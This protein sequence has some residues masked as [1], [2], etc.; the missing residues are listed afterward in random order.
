MSEATQ[1]HAYARL[2][3][4]GQFEC[5]M[6][7]KGVHCAACVQKIET[8]LRQHQEIV[9]ARLNFST[10]RL[11]VVWQGDAA[12]VD[13]WF[14]LVQ[15]LGYE[16]LPFDAR[17]LSDQNDDE[18]K[19]LLLCLGIAGFAM[20]NIMLLSIILWS[21]DATTLGMPARD[22]FHWVSALIALPAV[23]LGGRPFF[24][25]ALGALRQGRTNMDVPI[26]LAFILSCGTSLF[27]LFH[28]GEHV[29]FDSAVML[30]FFLLIGRFLDFRARASARSSARD[31]LS[32]MVGSAHVLDHDKISVMPIQDLQ[33]GMIVLVAMGER[34]P[35]DGVVIEGTSEID[36]SLLTGETM[37]QAIAA[38]QDIYSGALNIAAPLKIRIQRAAE[39]SLIADIV[40]LMEKAEQ[41][42]ARYVRIADR[43]ARLYTP[44]VHMLA[45]ATFIGWTFF[46]HLAWQQSL[47][48]ATAVLIITCPCALALA[49]PVVQVLAVGRLMKHGILVKSGDA[50]ERLA[51]I[52][53]VFLDKTGTLTLGRPSWMNAAAVMPEHIQIAASMAVHSRHPLSR[54]I[55]ESYQGDFLPMRV[56]EIPGKGLACDYHGQAIRLGNRYWCGDRAVSESPD[57]L[58]LWLNLAG[59]PTAVF[60]FSDP[61]RKD[62]AMTIAKLS[63]RNLSTTILSGDRAQ[64]V[65]GIAQKLG[66]TH[67]RGGMLPQEKYEALV[68]HQQLGHNVLM[69]GDGL[70][71]AP[72][73]QAANIAMSPATAI[74]ISQNVADIVFM[75][76]QLQSVVVAYD[77]A[78]LSQKLVYQN[79]ALSILYNLFAVPLAIAGHVTPMI[80]AIA[81]SSSSLVVIC[82]SF[83]MRVRS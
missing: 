55:V 31:I 20:G 30:M 11:C 10:N 65:K 73:L 61:L 23:G 50:L 35:A 52:D 27:E 38:G 54:A 9:S 82:N 28:H 47:M 3:P 32:L 69:V 51:A 63:L 26:S 74:D 62:A 12:Q 57:C 15:A 34:V 7:V 16:A 1:Y 75:G 76:E 80:A 2:N 19:S 6:T 29:Y 77:A 67:W 70:N 4:L 59:A 17:N 25:S 33:Q 58:E 21:T 14:A 68:A 40:R 18:G 8:A 56:D 64:V 79:F 36:N 41:A 45:A 71:D 46:Y 5:Y 42:N 53:S 48:I 66:I 37:P 13:Q 22:F 72:V 81:M 43:A 49:V 78:V 44:V 60:Y 24:R 83:R 39:N